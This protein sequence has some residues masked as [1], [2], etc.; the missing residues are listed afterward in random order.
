MQ[1]T[2]ISSVLHTVSALYV[3]LL[4]VLGI[5][6][7]EAKFVSAWEPRLLILIG[8]AVVLLETY[9]A[10]AQWRGSPSGLSLSIVLHFFF[11][12]AVL[13]TII[14]EYVKT[15]PSSPPDWFAANNFLFVS[16][17]GVA[18]IFAG[19]SLVFGRSLSS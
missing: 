17:L 8:S 16:L 10:A 14:V 15:Q 5:L 13:T 3:L 19:V 9:A 1:K 11:A 7:A 6:I 4:V 18:R 12:A 2:K